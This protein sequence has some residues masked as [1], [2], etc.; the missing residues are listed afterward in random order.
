[1]LLVLFR[2]ILLRVM[3]VDHVLSSVWLR[4]EPR[5]EICVICGFQISVAQL[6]LCPRLVGPGLFRTIQWHVSN[7][8]PVAY[9]PESQ[10]LY[11]RVIRRG[12]GAVDRRV[13]RSAI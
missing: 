7:P 1:M 12:G 11:T 9:V 4:P 8:L 6:Y 10:T 2:V 3:R 5:C 13:C